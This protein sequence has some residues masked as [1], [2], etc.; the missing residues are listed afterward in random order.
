MLTSVLISQHSHFE[1]LAQAWLL[2]GAKAFI[3]RSSN[4]TPV[5]SWPP[6]VDVNTITLIED[7]RVGRIKIGELCV[8]APD[9]IANH[10]R[11]QVEAE[12][13]SSLI[14]S[15]RNLR[16]VTTKLIDTQDHLLAMYDLTESTRQEVDLN[17]VLKLLVHETARLVKS[18]AAFMM[19][20]QPGESWIVHYYPQK[21]L[22]LEILEHLLERVRKTDRYRLLT[23][24]D[25]ESQQFSFHNLLLLPIRLHDATQAALGL[26]NKSGGDFLFPDI[27][28]ARA[29]ADY[30]SARV[31]NVLLYRNNLKQAKMHTEMEMA[32]RVQRDLLPQKMPAISGID[33][34]ASSRPALQVGG[35]FYDF[36]QL[37]KRPF[38]FMVGD[39]SGKGMAA[40]ILM[41]M[42]RTVMRS[43]VYDMALRTP[44]IVVE[45]SNKHL[46]DDFT[47]VNMFATIFIGQYHPCKQELMYANA[48]HSPVI[49]CPAGGRARLL[50]ADGT[51]MG[52]LPTSFSENQRIAFMPGDVL[53][54]ATDGLNEAYNDQEELFGYKRLLTLVES[55]VTQ[56]AQEIAEELYRAVNSFSAGIPQYDDQTVVV[57][58]GVAANSLPSK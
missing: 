45:R 2:S 30:A 55:L 33:F 14:Q 27:K 24:Q 48:G 35:D 5:A 15:M 58:K 41:A 10:V 12:L 46:Y 8:V 31:E 11:L 42:T 40:A 37:D 26:V 23:E 17:E 32:Q 21:I 9:R 28:L 56:S 34:W 7:I 54:V 43:N 22:D 36:L 6:H 13:V 3:V 16:D 4:G 57:V 19:V 52:I 51:P 53:V 1:S 29:I 20:R 25:K 44:A 18:E 39:I 38:T 50:E 49:F 47:E